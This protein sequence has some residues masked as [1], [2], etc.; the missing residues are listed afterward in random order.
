[1]GA[2]K[3]GREMACLRAVACYPESHAVG[4]QE[5]MLRAQ[6]YTISKTLGKHRLFQRGTSALFW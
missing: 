1:M 5:I 6:K 4:L 2:A 3:I